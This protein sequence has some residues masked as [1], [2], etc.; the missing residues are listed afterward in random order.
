MK[1]KILIILILFKSLLKYNTFIQRQKFVYGLGAENG[2]DEE[3]ASQSL[4]GIDQQKSLFEITVIS[5]AEFIYRSD[6]N[7]EQYCEWK[8][9]MFMKQKCNRSYFQADSSGYNTYSELE[10]SYVRNPHTLNTF[11]AFLL[12]WVS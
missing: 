11:W 1:Y 12:Y 5:L 7:S 6:K 3:C 2:H 8:V 4:H 10:S 9:D